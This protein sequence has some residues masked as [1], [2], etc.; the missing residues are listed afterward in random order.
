MVT[1]AILWNIIDAYLLKARLETEGIPACI[2]DEHL[3]QT[4]WTLI[5]ALGGIRV[6]V[7]FEFEE[8]AK[9]LV[10]AF[11]E[12]QAMVVTPP[13]PRC[14]SGDSFRNASSKNI[15]TIFLVILNLPLP[16]FHRLKCRT[17]GHCWEEDPESD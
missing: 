10:K 2:P 3:V 7:P 13:C 4:K 8:E 5:C 1:V 15:S 11:Q 12:R 9:E 17:C 14:G 16:F 6:Q